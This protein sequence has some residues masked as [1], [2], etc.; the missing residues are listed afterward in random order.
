MQEILSNQKRFF[1][2]NNVRSLR[3]PLWPELSVAKIWLEADK[4]STFKHYMPSDWDGGNKV[5]R[6]FFWTILITLAP[7]YVEHLIID[8]RKQRL[9]AAQEKSLASRP[10]NITPN[11]VEPLLSQPFMSRKY[12]ENLVDI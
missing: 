12:S 11:W 2:K 5:E 6:P 10:I 3:V 7:E 1:Y 8:C 9:L 4:L